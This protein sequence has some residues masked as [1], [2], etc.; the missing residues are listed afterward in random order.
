MSLTEYVTK[1]YTE[2]LLA[3]M[4]SGKMKG[5]LI[6][7]LQRGPSEYNISKLVDKLGG[8]GFIVPVP[9]VYSTSPILTALPAIEQAIAIK[10]THSAIFEPKEADIGTDAVVLSSFKQQIKDLF[11]EQ[12]FLNANKLDDHTIPEEEMKGYCLRILQIDIDIQRVY[13]E[14]AHYRKTGEVPGIPSPPAV[15]KPLSI[16][17]LHIRISTLK[18][19]IARDKKNPKRQEH[20]IKWETELKQRQ[21]EYDAIR[22]QAKGAGIQ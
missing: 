15:E 7:T 13:A 3:F 18:K 20:L 14:M 19:N 16:L 12:S 6:N 9:V 22:D 8:I 5:P 10:E 11:K 21:L 2:A 4:Q 17:E 1:N